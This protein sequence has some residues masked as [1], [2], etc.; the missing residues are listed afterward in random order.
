LTNEL[1]GEVQ[2]LLNDLDL[3]EGIQEQLEIRFSPLVVEIPGDDTLL[4]LANYLDD[5]LK[6]IIINEV[7]DQV[8]QLD[9]MRQVKAAI[10]GQIAAA[11]DRIDDMVDEVAAHYTKLLTKYIEKQLAPLDKKVNA[12]LG[13]LRDFVGTGE[14]SGHARV[15]GDSLREL[16]VDGKFQWKVPDTMEFKG[17]LVIR[18]MH[19][20]MDGGACVPDGRLAYEMVIGAKDAKMDWLAPDMKVTVELRTILEMAEEGG[21]LEVKGIG[22][23][24]KT[25]SRINL[26]G[27]EI[28]RIAAYM[29]VSPDY[30]CHIAAA[31]NMRFDS[32]AVGGGVFFGSTCSIA[33]LEMIDPDVAGVLG[34]PPFTGVYLYGEGRAPILN[35]GCPLRVTVGVGA[36][37]F[38]FVEGHTMG[39]KALGE[40]SGEAICLV[41][42]KGQLKVIGLYQA[43]TGGKVLDGTLKLSGKAGKCPFCVKLSRTYGI[44]YQNNN[45]SRK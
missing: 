30:G 13:P 23:G 19:A 6:K 34:A 11:F 38:Y 7:R 42:V 32:Y 5:E 15:V 43:S 4:D 25:N 8:L 35:F 40:V 28:T 9:V 2:Q 18:E 27:F 3:E 37:F 31:L 22:G 45:F 26:E 14:I 24:F 16:R 39:F 12:A 29:G 20:A 41:T 1:L 17:F 33:P 44:R 21:D 10:D 36:G